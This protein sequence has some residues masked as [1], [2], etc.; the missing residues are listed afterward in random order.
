MKRIGFV[1][2]LSMLVFC[3]CS[4]TDELEKNAVRID[5][6]DDG[7][8]VAGKPAETDASNEVYVAK[9]I[10]YYEEGKDFTYGEG[11]E[12][13][14]HSVEEANAHTVVHIAKPGRYVLSGKLS[15]GQIAV[16][17]GEDA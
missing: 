16:D 14:S 4:K 12:K 9:D 3:G 7:I 6:S 5:L 10:V 17:L 8:S 11:T 1:L 15:L 2:I 13:D